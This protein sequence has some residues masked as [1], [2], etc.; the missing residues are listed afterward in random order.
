M[1]LQLYS[2]FHLNLAFS[3]IEEEQRPAVIERCYWP[4]LKLIRD[5]QLPLGVEATGFTLETIAAIDPGWI[6]ELRELCLNG[7][8]EFVGSGYVQLIGPLVPAEVNRHNQALGLEVYQRLLG[9]QPRLALVNEQ[10]YSAGMVAHYQQAGYQ[11][12]IMEWDNPSRSHPEWDPEWRYF[13]QRAKG[14]AGAELP[15][16]WNKSL[17]FQQFQRYAHGELELDRYLQHLEKHLGEEERVFSLYGN[18]AEI[19]DYRPGRFATESQQQAGEWQHLTTLYQHL[20]QDERFALLPP[21]QVLDYLD[22]PKAGQLLELQSAAQPIPVKKQAKYNITRWAVTGRDDLR[23]NS[24]CHQLYRAIA[25]EGGCSE[26]WRELCF[27]WSSDFRTHI[28][29]TRWQAYQQRLEQ[30]SARLLKQTTTKEPQQLKAP[31]KAFNIAEEPG[32]LKVTSKDLELRLNLRRGLAIDRLTF[33][34]QPE[35]PLLGTLPHGFYDDI[36]LGADFYTGHLVAEIPGDHKVTDLGPV[37]PEFRYF[38]DSLE[39]FGTVATPLG[40]ITK[41]LQLSAE[42][43]ELSLNYQLDWP[44]FPQAALRLGFLTLP[45]ASYSAANL[46]FRTHNGGSELETFYIRGQQIDHLASVTPLVT[47]SQGLGATEGIFEIG[48]TRQMLS[49]EFDPGLTAHVIHRP[50]D[51]SYFYRVVFSARELD[52][53]CCASR[54]TSPQLPARFS[55]RISLPAC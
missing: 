36:D 41:S 23:I 38:D 44:V 49:V 43:A 27:L 54:Q 17:P 14:L 24:R 53:S 42:G 12:L 39:I 40:P 22:R 26:D 51:K 11:G 16:V 46:M 8:A 50:V 19:F 13:P 48:D 21:S 35:R 28:T 37:K 10:A 5:Q 2:V 20:Q 31:A 18:D 47:A 30:F 55:F 29:E 52:D 15:L 7:P 6:V 32:F 33:A 4:L 25:A 1:A 34:D 45:P 9:L 3:S